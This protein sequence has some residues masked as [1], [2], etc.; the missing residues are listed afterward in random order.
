VSAH[1][2]LFAAR[3][4]ESGGAWLSALTTTT[5]PM[6]ERHALLWVSR[7]GDRLFAARIGAART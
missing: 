4:P 5:T 2:T 7:K 1:R 3:F 6:P